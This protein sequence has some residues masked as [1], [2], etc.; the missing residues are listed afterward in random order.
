MY[1]TETSAQENIRL[2]L[3]IRTYDQRW[4]PLVLTVVIAGLSQIN[5]HKTF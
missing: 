3:Y 4:I 5:D 1:A 2:R